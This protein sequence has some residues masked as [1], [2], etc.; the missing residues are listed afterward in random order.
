MSEPQ[1]IE[2]SA[3]ASVGGKV[4][5]IRYDLS[6]EYHFRLDSKYTI[7]DDW[8]EEQIAGFRSTMLDTLRAEVEPH[9]DKE[10]Q[11]LFDQKAELNA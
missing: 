6:A 5:L 3:S 10:V 2:I 11:A 1:C 9:A 7:P 8:T 4:Q